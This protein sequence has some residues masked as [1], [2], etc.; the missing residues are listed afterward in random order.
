MKID[1]V[2]IFI[3]PIDVGRWKLFQEHYQPINTCIE[4]GVFAITNG[5][6]LLDFDKHGVLR[7]IRRNDYLYTER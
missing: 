6:A 2:T 1:P 4:A 3:E 7:A 5:T